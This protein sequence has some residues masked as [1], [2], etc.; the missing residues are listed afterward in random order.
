MPLQTL[1]ER[2][3]P[4]KPAINNNLDQLVEVELREQ[5]ERVRISERA[6]NNQPIIGEPP[7]LKDRH[8]QV[9]VDLLGGQQIGDHVGGLLGVDFEALQ[10]EA[11]HAH[12]IRQEEVRV[13]K[14]VDLVLPLFVRQVLLTVVI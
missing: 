1:H 6:S 8:F 4:Q 13:A 14:S 7:A 9:N 3:V 11:E 12:A 2:S 10:A 5:E